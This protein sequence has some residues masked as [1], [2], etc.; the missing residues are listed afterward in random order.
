MRRWMAGTMLAVLLLAVLL[1]ASGCGVVMNREYSDL[2]DKTAAL[3]A[4]TAARAE[5]GELTPDQMTAAL[6]RQ[7]ETWQRFID[8]RDGKAGEQ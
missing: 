2:L 1:L 8:A 3:S 6:V 4:E 5:A 7:A